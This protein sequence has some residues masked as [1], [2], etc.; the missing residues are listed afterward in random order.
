MGS[1]MDMTERLICTHMPVLALFIYCVDQSFFLALL[2]L[3]EEINL[4]YSVGLLVTDF[5]YIYLRSISP[6]F[7]KILDWSKG[8]FFVM[9]GFPG[10][11]V[12]KDLPVNSRDLRDM[13]SIPGSGRCPGVGNG[14]PLQYSCLENPMDRGAW[15]A[16]V[17]GVTESDMT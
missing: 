17:P 10:G 2:L 9:S 1:Q 11:S 14:N 8:S 7:C 6:S 15:P 16:T 13:G 4:S 3:P 5:A 12:V